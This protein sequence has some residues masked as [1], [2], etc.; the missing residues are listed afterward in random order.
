MESRVWPQVLMPAI[1]HKAC[2]S[3]NSELMPIGKESGF[4]TGEMQL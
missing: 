2:L 1:S 4:Y 3:R